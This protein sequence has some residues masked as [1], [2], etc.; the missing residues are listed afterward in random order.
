MIP[1]FR[2]KHTLEFVILKNT[3]ARKLRTPRNDRVRTKRGGVCARG[4]EGEMTPVLTPTSSGCEKKTGKEGKRGSVSETESI[5]AEDPLYV[6]LVQN[7]FE[8][9]STLGY[10]KVS[11]D[12]VAEKLGVTKSAIYWRFKSKKGL[13]LA[14]CDY[15]Y[16]LWREDIFVQAR[17]TSDP[18][19]Q[20][21]R[22]IRATVKRCLFDA[23]NRFFSAEV[24]HASFTDQ[25]ICKSWADFLADGRKRMVELVA[26]A[27]TAKSLLSEN[28]RINTEWLFFTMEGIKQHS[29][30]EPEIINRLQ[31]ESMVAS[32]THIALYGPGISIK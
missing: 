8:L 6:E 11:T 4:D 30:F 22:V 12:M 7:A 14:T 3:L 24:F 17:S 18:V 32:L 1:E 19:L 9:F 23:Q 25:D 29:G 13:L 27:L 21:E 15:Y 26:R 28:A 16:R 31:C 10:R 5:G 2:N 20:L